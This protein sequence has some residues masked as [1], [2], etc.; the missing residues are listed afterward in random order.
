[1]YVREVHIQ[2]CAFD[3]ISHSLLTILLLGHSDVGIVAKT[4]L[5]E[6]WE[7]CILPVGSVVR[8]CRKGHRHPQISIQSLW[9]KGMLQPP[10]FLLS[11]LHLWFDFWNNLLFRQKLLYT[12]YMCVERNIMTKLNTR[13]VSRDWKVEK[14]PLLESLKLWSI[15]SRGIL[16]PIPILLRRCVAIGWSLRLWP[17]KNM[18]LKTFLLEHIN[19][20]KVIAM[21]NS[22]CNT[23]WSPWISILLHRGPRPR[24]GVTLGLKCPIREKW[25]CLK[26]CSL[27]RVI[28]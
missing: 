22:A 20:L 3:Y 1:M 17:D 2:I 9:K 19:L 7:V 11:L 13:G 12:W 5:T 24:F 16:L 23:P 4:S 27:Y 28:F 15:I 6:D 25:L 26:W 18:H 8:V 10:V 21:H 14:M